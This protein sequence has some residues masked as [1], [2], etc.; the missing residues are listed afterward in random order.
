MRLPW[1]ALRSSVDTS[2]AAYLINLVRAVRLLGAEAIITGIRPSVAQTIISVGVDLSGIPTRSNLRSG[3]EYCTR[4][5]NGDGRSRF[6][7]K[8]D[9]ALAAPILPVGRLPKNLI[10]LPQSLTTKTKRVALNEPR[11][12]SSLQ[13]KSG[14]PKDC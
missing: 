1:P 7:R 10:Q 2:T 5:C 3:L 9:G 6:R 4:P 8:T 13:Q 14:L 12:S 11:L